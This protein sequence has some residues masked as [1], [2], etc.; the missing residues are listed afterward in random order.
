L[1]V[2]ANPARTLAGLD[3]KAGKAAVRHKKI[4]A[5]SHD[6]RLFALFAQQHEKRGHLLRRGRKSHNGSRSANAKGCM[7]AKRFVLAQKKAGYP[8]AQFG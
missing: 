2:H 7:G 8:R 1:A 5:V 6:E 4:C 3:N